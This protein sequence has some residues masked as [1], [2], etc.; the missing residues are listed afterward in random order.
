MNH[1]H[2]VVWL[3]HQKARVIHFNAAD[4]ETVK[5]TTDAPNHL[6]HHLNQGHQVGLRSGRRTPE[7]RHY[8]DAIVAALGEAKAWLVL[9]PGEAKQE[10]SKHV[11]EHAPQLK[12]RMASVE[13]ADHPSDA[14]I[15]A[16]ARAFFKAADRMTPQR[17]G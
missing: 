13:A 6:I 14:Q 2:A 11:A 16:R 5:V 3:D 15:V 17:G 7:D 1:Y 12:G 10:F 4:A 8:Y 9:G